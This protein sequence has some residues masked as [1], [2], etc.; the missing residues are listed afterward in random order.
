MSIPK[1]P[2]NI[3]SARRALA[4]YNFV[5][6]PERIARVSPVPENLWERFPQALPPLQDRFDGNRHSGWIDCCIT[7]ASPVYV[8][9]ALT[10]QQA[11]EGKKA[12]DLSE[13]FYVQ[14]PDQ[15]VIPGSTLRGM[16]RALIEIVSYSKVS[17]VTDAKLIYRAVGDTTS[18]GER[19]RDRVMTDH[20]DK[21]YTPR[22]LGGHIIRRGSDWYIQP[23]CEVNGTT[24]AVL[25]QP[26]RETFYFD[27]LKKRLACLEH[28][29]NAYRVYVKVG[30][31]QF[32]DVRGGFISVRQALAY[33]PSPVPKTG[34]VEGTLALS[35]PMASK[36]S[37]AVIFVP[38]PAS[39]ALRL[40]DDQIADYREQISKEQKKL[41]GDNGAL[42]DG[43]P[44]FYTL[45]DDGTVEFF[46]HC[47]ML[48]LPYPKSPRDFV[49]EELRREA[50]IDLTEAIFGFTRQTPSRQVNA[51]AGRLSFSDARLLPDQQDIW[52][53]PHRPITPRILGTP[54]P[55]SFQHYLVQTQPNRF[56]VGRDRR[57]H[58]KFETRLADYTDA[59]TVIRGHKLYWHKGAVTLDD[60][61]LQQDPQGKAKDKV[62]TAIRPVR[63]DVKFN[64][65]IRFDNL[66]DVELGV[67][68]WVLQ[69]AADERYRLSVGMG[70]PLGLGAV[71]IES[72]L[73]LIDREARYTTLFD[74]DN[75]AEGIKDE[76]T[77]TDVRQRAVPAFERFVLAQL[78]QPSARRLDELERIRQLLAM[79][80]WPG[81]NK[82][83]TRYLEIERQ[84]PQAKR[85]KRN[86]YKHPEDRPVLPGPLTVWQPGVSATLMQQPLSSVT[87]T[88]Q[89]EQIKTGEVKV[90]GLGPLKS[91][92]F[93]KPHEEGPDVF[94]HREALPPGETTLIQ[95]R[96]VRYIL[97]EDGEENTRPKAKKVLP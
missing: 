38:G 40:S 97:L 39:D 29:H 6:L 36:R 83:Q 53:L 51:Y 37:E 67:L 75:W 41:L 90:F 19:Y 95:G 22:V 61:E 56:Q 5:E 84:D 31:Y 11:T 16:F 81:P 17:D 54:K 87:P 44:V 64:F 48:R 43:Q 77:T 1:Q 33:D 92:G 26:A 34:W 2:Q 59:N 13:F 76:K 25:K 23:A 96:P 93:I 45:N 71:K 62:M 85:G 91:Y 69:I 7:T 46:G 52:L 8:R 57:G 73:K 74:A 66:S 78:N 49:P 88:E 82:E 14:E 12:K 86:E 94:V 89:P 24:F 58:P 50:E 10:A 79:L 63:V 4:P 35:G 70:K 20:K 68:L 80:S 18:H 21:Q 15:P 30:P 65:R 28:C 32:Q 55:T 60:I 3:E 47:R 27:N 42:N 9:A 72:D